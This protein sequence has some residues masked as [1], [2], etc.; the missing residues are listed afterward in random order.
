MGAPRP[1]LVS[2]LVVAILGVL[3]NAG[4]VYTRIVYFNYPTLTAPRLFDSRPVGASPRPAPL[5]SREAD[6]VF[7][8]TPAD[9]PKYRSFDDFLERNHTVA[10]V[11]IHEDRVVY[12]RYFDGVSATTLLPDFSI[13]KTVAALL[14]GCAISDGLLDSVDRP[15]VSY[16]PELRSRRGYGDITIDE[17]LRMTAGIDFNEESVEG[18]ALYY[19]TDLRPY[20][21]GYDVKWP[22][23]THYLYGSLSTQILWDLLHRR[24]GGRTVTRYFE[25]RLWGPLGAERGASWSLDSASSGI[26]KLFAGFNATARDHARFGLLFLHG[27]FLGGRRI[28]PEAFVRQS[29]APD[30]VAGTVHG[31]DGWVRRGKY[32]WFLTLDGRAYFAKGYNGQYVFVVPATQTVFVRFGKGYGEVDWPSLFLRLSDALK[33][34]GPAVDVSAL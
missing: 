24:L 7:R 17:L 25:E 3:G 8:L 19:T 23:G 31:S 26:E 34:E 6:S 5:D 10:F 4:C 30:P 13:S 16:V 28:L 21:Y 2:L 29:L 33:A 32:Q 22:P 27:G 11:A 18:A 15:L 12:E 20:I 9:A 1:G 14:V